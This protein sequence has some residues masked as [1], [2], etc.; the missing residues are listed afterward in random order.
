MLRF[1]AKRVGTLLAVGLVFC[2]AA[3]LLPATMTRE[4]TRLAV[5][6]GTAM[7]LN[8]LV[9]ATGLISLG[10]GLFFGFG[11]Y[12][13]AIGTIKHNMSWGSSAL[14]GLALALPLSLIV[15]L[16]A[17]RARHLF[18][19]LLT[20]AIGQVGYILVAGHYELT[21]GDD[22][23]VGVKIPALLENDLVRHFF[24]VGLL[25]GVGLLLLWL[26]A[27]PFGAMLTAVRD[28]ADRVAS[29]GGNPKR[30]EIAAMVV[31]G[32]LGTVFGIAAAT[33]EGNV[34]PLMFSWTTSA[35]F[36]VMI[37]LGGRSIFLGPI[38]GAVIL[39][40][41]RLY[42]QIHS[43]NSDLV[44]GLLVILCAILFP[45]GLGL[46][47]KPLV[48]WRERRRRGAASTTALVE[49]AGDRR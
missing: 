5:L 40:L 1:D 9:G 4:L 39:E 37:A 42:V 17:L 12:A 21:G 2:A 7:T 10:Q 35:M 26:L 24:A 38:I 44:V 33:T 8:L 29:L 45:E 14:L 30:Y 27:S 23:L 25:V 18:F 36:L 46:A 48:A 3:F 19:G 32:M 11:A 31:A 16:I 22:G 49:P 41:S 34:E 15:A 28:N 47:L 43:S 13:V 20:L 6:A